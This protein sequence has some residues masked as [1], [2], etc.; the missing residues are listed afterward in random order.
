[1]RAPN[2]RLTTRQPDRVA[3]R[4]RDRLR[5]WV[6]RHVLDDDPYGSEALQQGGTEDKTLLWRGVGL[7]LMLGSALISITGLRL[8]WTWLAG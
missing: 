5:S 7:A 2:V 3:A 6:E 8:L 4:A 1:M